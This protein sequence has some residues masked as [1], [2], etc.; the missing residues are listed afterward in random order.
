MSAI[1]QTLIFSPDPTSAERLAQSLE[2]AVAQI[3]RAHT[4]E[5]ALAQVNENALD[6]VLIHLDRDPRGGLALASQI[7]RLHPDLAVLAVGRDKDPDLILSGLR[8]GITDYLVL[9]ENGVQIPAALCNAL[10]RNAGNAPSGELIAVY[11]LKGGQGVTTV[12]VNLADHIQSLTGR[13]VLLADL[14]PFRGDAAVYLDQPCSYTPADLIRDLQRMDDQ[15]LFSSLIRHKNRFHLLGTSGDI[16]DADQISAEDIAAMI[17]L[18]KRHFHTIVADL[19]SDCSEKNL[20]VLESASRILLV[21]QQT[22]PE[23]KSLQSVIDF[24]REI[25]PN[26]QR[27]EVVINRYN[28]N[29]DLTAKD[30]AALFGCPVTGTIASH[31]SAITHAV[32]QGKTLST[33]CPQKKINRDFN[34][35]ASRLTGTGPAK[36][37]QPLLK[38]L[39]AW[40][41]E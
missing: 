27:L 23:I 19:P 31:Y 2:P 7:R 36:T 32:N 5:N 24:F 38:M 16:S 25:D 8:A 40:I 14:N 15:L 26:E 30:L 10:N 1:N 29:S 35:L 34:A 28:P 33:A 11:S 20:A 21:V 39:T 4:A 3:H 41:R 12:A 13:K 22:V 18:L 37:Q 17:A 6:A 9:G